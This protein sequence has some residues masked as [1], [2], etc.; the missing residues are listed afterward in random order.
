MIKVR[1]FFTKV[2]H[3]EHWPTYMFYVPL[4][5]YFAYKALLARSLTF[6]LAVNPAIK[7]SGMGSESKFKTLN[8]LP[9]GYIPKS[10][11]VSVKTDFNLILVALAKAEIDFPLIAK[12][13]IG[14]RGFLVK[15]VD[16]ESDLENYL[17]LNKIDIILQEFVDYQ[18]ECGLFYYKIP[19]ENKGIITSITLKKFITVTG[20]GIDNLGT[21]ILNDNRAFLYHKLFEKLHHK[22]YNNVP[23]KDEII[24]LTVIGNHSKGTQFVNANYLID[25]ELEEFLDKLTAKLP[26]FNY[27]RF[28]IK[29]NNLDQLKKA[30]SA[31]AVHVSASKGYREKRRCMHSTIP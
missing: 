5:P 16:N 24:K 12:P 7:Y 1:I 8:L 26:N 13:D 4:I 15:K 27:G 30:C 28:D 6:F 22:R 18:H 21:L 20:N 3:S 10:I 14:F 2:L 11:L 9:K 25:I 17:H 29:F 23:I 19:G 31:Q